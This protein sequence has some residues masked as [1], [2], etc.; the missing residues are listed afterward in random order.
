MGKEQRSIQKGGGHAI[1]VE[2]RPSQDL[3]EIL[4]GRLMDVRPTRFAILAIVSV[5]WSAA[6][7]LGALATFGIF[8]TTDDGSRAAQVVAAIA[9]AALGGVIARQ[10]RAGTSVEVGGLVRKSAWRTRRIAWGE[11]E[12]LA[13]EYGGRFGIWLAPRGSGPL[14]IPSSVHVTDR[15]YAESA[16]EFVNKALGLAPIALHQRERER[17]RGGR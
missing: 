9:F 5:C 12:G 4:S 11:V 13:S 15:A 1:D 10:A 14:L 3:T 6:L 2:R 8:D 16:V 7:L 17:K